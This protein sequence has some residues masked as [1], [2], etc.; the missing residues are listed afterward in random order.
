MAFQ[1]HSRAIHMTR[2]SYGTAYQRG[3]G[4]TLRFLRSRGVP[5]ERAR[6]VSQ[7][8]WAKGWE[9]LDQLRDDRLV[10][11][12]VNAIALNVQNRLQQNEPAWQGL[13]ESAPLPDG[14]NAV[15]VTTPPHANLAA[16]DMARILKICCPVDRVLLRHQMVGLTPREIA[17]MRGV[18]EGAMRVR[19]LRAR[20]SAR[21]RL[22]QLGR[23]S[24]ALHQSVQ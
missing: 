13:P 4:Q 22:E 3:F 21:M 20:Q 6:D 15:G 7:T 19:L 10:F 14:G 1:V 16:I 2:E 12:W 5:F 18:P 9:R 23:F 24:P 11:T 17:R 8:A